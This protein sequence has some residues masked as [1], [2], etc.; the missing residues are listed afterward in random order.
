VA[1]IVASLEE[2]AFL[3]GAGAML[4]IFGIVMTPFAIFPLS[5][6]GWADGYFTVKVRSKGLRQKLQDIYK[7]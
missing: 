3:A 4:L 6:T 2:S 7:P 1:L 5:V